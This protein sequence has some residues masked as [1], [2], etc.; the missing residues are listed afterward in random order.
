M[1]EGCFAQARRSVK[2][3]V[4]EGF[5]ALAGGFDENGKILFDLLLPN[6]VVE[7]LRTQ[8]VIDAVVRFGFGVERAV[9]GRCHGLNY[10]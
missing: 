8:G 4:V 1:R 10:T 7:A 2:E 3:D 6:Q 5:F 9:I